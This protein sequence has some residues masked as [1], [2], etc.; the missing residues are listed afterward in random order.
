[1]AGPVSQTAI[2][3]FER[4]ERAWASDGSRRTQSRLLLLAFFGS[5]AW[6]EL[7]RH[8]I[9]DTFLGRP[10][11]T[12]HLAAIS[13]IVTLLLIAESLDLVFGMAA[14]VSS[15]LGKQL[16]IFSLV[17]LRK[18]LDEL[19]HLG[20]PVDVAHHA[21]VILRMV[22]DATGAVLVFGATVLYARL[23]R[24]E[25][26]SDDADD[27]D[28]F[29]A[30]K[31]LICFGLLTAFFVIAALTGVESLTLPADGAS[32]KLDLAFFEVFFTALIFADVAIVLASIGATKEHSVI[33]RNFAF[34]TVTVFLRLALAAPPFY[35]GA[36]GV[37]AALLAVA[38]VWLSGRAASEPRG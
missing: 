16:Q 13:W 14:S 8:G 29:V 36:L 7:A 10:M 25:P 3:A 4:L 18:S 21:D 38:T 15:A 33:F 26:I 22:A 20:E 2:S 34:A 11:P 31:K 1:M 35:N 24:H 12:N 6:I 37:G 9:A 5:I 17:L 27:V 32:P 30:T 19:P 23:L 28:R